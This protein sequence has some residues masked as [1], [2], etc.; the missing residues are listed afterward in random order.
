MFRALVRASLAAVTLCGAAVAHP[1]PDIPVRC[2]FDEGGVGTVRVEI[3]LRLFD[4]EPSAAPYFV[5]ESLPGK[6]ASW[7]AEQIGKAR[8]FIGRNLEFF[9]EQN[10]RV[11]PKFDWAF[12]VRGGVALA[13]P[14]DPVVLTGA[15]R[16]MIGAGV[17][18]F[19][20]RST[21]QNRWSVLFLN[22]IP[23]RQIGRTQV[24]FP[25]ETSIVLDLHDPARADSTAPLAG[26]VGAVAWWR[27]LGEF[28]REGFRHVLPLG[29]DHILFVLGL[30]LLQREWRPL[31]WQVSAFT[32]A[33]TLTLGLATLGAVT[34]NPRLVEPLIAASIAFVAVENIARPR[35]T[36]WRLAVV[37]GFGLVHG[38]GFASALRDLNLPTPSL[39]AGLLG[40]NLGVEGGQLAVIALAFLATS[41]LRDAA[42]YRSWIVV[43]GSALIALTG[44]WWTVARVLGI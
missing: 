6:P 31:I 19:Q 33:H 26:A 12:T 42:R 29:L 7:R 13:K 3:D 30:F 40:F 32:A 22:Q 20:I 5:N 17:Q 28:C 35:Y 10:G 36:R 4:A 1:V 44:A 34:A 21:P 38:L 18:G 39:L 11:S 8:D 9:L 37:F 27:T 15:W 43:P 14:D 23:G 16:T 2:S 25:G 41:W 24:L